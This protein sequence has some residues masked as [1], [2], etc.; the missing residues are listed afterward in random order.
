MK[1]PSPKSLA[2]LLRNYILRI[3]KDWSGA[4]RL[5]DQRVALRAD[6]KP[7]FLI[8]NST[9]H[10]RIL[11]LY[12]HWRYAAGLGPERDM[13]A[14]KEDGDR[15]S[16]LCEP[17]ARAVLVHNLRSAF[18]VGSIFRTAD[19]FGF[20]EIN[21]SGY[22][23]GIEHPA[24]KSAARGCET[25]LKSR[26][27]ESPIECII[28]Y[29]EQNYQVLALE[30]DGLDIKSFEWPEKFLFILGNEELGIAK[31][32]LDLCDSKISIQMRGRKA[33]LNVSC[34]FAVAAGL[35]SNFIAK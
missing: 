30:T 7:D 9:Q 5:Y 15:S 1:A 23:P 16:P 25:W 17:F 35:S 26:R 18:N 34:A 3:G 27:W 33:S 28:F 4:A 2:D 10:K 24:L 19:C 11:D 32:L 31:E 14:G 21:L 22:T 20:A 13:L 8:G 29:K 6:F 12:L